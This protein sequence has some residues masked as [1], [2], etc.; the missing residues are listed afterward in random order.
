[1]DHHRPDPN[2]VSRFF[3]TRQRIEEER[4]LRKAFLYPVNS[5][6]LARPAARIRVTDFRCGLFSITPGVAVFAS[7]VGDRFYG[8]L[9]SAGKDMRGACSRISWTIGVCIRVHPWRILRPL[10]EIFARWMQ[11]FDNGHGWPRMHT[12]RT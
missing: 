11:S 7:N 5:T 4:P 12:D 6:G 9:T 1:V 10:P 3:N 8:M 2:D